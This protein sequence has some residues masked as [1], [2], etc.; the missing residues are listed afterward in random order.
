MEDMML[1]DKTFKCKG[2][3]P[4][5]GVTI[6]DVALRAGVSSSTV[7]RILAGYVV[8]KPETKQRVLDIVQEMGYQPNFQAKR[9]ALFRNKVS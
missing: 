5:S 8:Y 4:K 1:L 7:S 9:L 3:I 2:P 6:Y